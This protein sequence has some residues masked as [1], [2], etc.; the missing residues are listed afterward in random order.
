MVKRPRVH[1]VLLQ[2]TERTAAAARRD[3]RSILQVPF[4]PLVLLYISFNGQGTRTGTLLV[5]FVSSIL[6]L[7]L[8]QIWMSMMMLL[9]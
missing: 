3:D 8:M 4:T 5:S 9:F 1:A 2:I 6:I 7:T